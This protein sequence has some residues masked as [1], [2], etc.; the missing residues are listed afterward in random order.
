MPVGFIEG[1]ENSSES[2]STS[3]HFKMKKSKKNDVNHRLVTRSLTCL[4]NESIFIGSYNPLYSGFTRHENELWDAVGSSGLLRIEGKPG[5]AE[6]V[7][8]TNEGQMVE[9]QMAQLTAVLQHKEDELVALR[10]QT[11]VLQQREDVLVMQRH[12]AAAS[13][14]RENE[15]A[16]LRQQMVANNER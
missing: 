4:G 8:A 7:L 9:E 15:L 16:A 10:Q 11:T 3:T 14:Q 13:Q 1:D 2:S 6:Q 12:Q 5:H